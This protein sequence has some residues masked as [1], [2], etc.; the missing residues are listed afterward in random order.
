[1]SPNGSFSTTCVLIII[2][3]FIPTMIRADNVPMVFIFG[4]SLFDVGTN[5]FLKTKARADVK[6]NG[7]D[8]RGSQPT[9][10]FSN[11]YNTADFIGIY[12]DH[13]F[14]KSCKCFVCMYM[15]VKVLIMHVCVL[16]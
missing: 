10:R 8:Y 2:T 15:H 6:F 13:V 12:M 5:N 1:M 14:F 11:G 9:G 7:I 4:D 3:I 16:I